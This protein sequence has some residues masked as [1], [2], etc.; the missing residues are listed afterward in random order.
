MVGLW[1]SVAVLAG[2]VTEGAD[3]L[4]PE[5]LYINK[6]PVTYNSKPSLHFIMHPN[7]C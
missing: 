2:K 4:F 6:T 5:R 3:S 7:R 1:L